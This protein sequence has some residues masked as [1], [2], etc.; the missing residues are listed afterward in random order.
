MKQYTAPTVEVIGSITE[1]TNGAVIIG[2]DF[3]SP[4]DD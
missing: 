2:S 1:L 3:G 4:I